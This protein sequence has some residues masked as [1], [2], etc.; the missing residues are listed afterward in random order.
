MDISFLIA[1][2]GAILL[3]Y[4]AQPTGICMVRGVAEWLKEKNSIGVMVLLGSVS[5][6]VRFGSLAAPQDSIIAMTAFGC[7]ADVQTSS[8][9]TI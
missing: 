3:G 7:E 8:I 6:H 5:S 2:L 9:S 4:L 1:L